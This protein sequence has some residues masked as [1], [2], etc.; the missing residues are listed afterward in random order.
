MGKL[1]FYFDMERCV[2]C[3]ACQIACKDR[4]DLPTGVNF[5]RVDHYETGEFPN[6]RWYHTSIACNHCT[7]PACVRNCPSGATFIAEDGT[8]QHDDEMCIFCQ[9]CVSKCPY[10]APVPVPSLG[11]VLKCDSCKPLR[12]AGM[13]PACVDACIQRALEFGDV[14]ELAKKYGDKKL[15]NVIPCLPEPATQPSLLINAKPCAEESEF[16]RIT[17]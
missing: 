16:T 14:D 8:V 10:G 3:H 1:G 7:D 2:G 13:N 6:A 15:V 12:D 5:R 17:L 9:T 11:V 4:A